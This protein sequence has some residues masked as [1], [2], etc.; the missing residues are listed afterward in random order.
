MAKLLSKYNRLQVHGDSLFAHHHQANTAFRQIVACQ[1]VA[2]KHKDVAEEASPYCADK[3]DLAMDH[4]YVRLSYC[5]RWALSPYM[6]YPNVGQVT[7]PVL[8]KLK[9]H[10]ANHLVITYLPT[11]DNLRSIDP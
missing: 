6:V 8:A 2:T 10:G 5:K 4:G 7:Q 3:F 1:L 11:S 9:I